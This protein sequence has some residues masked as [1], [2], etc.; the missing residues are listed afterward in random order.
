M[1]S[2]GMSRKRPLGFDK[3]NV[4]PSILGIEVNDLGV[5]VKQPRLAFRSAAIDNDLFNSSKTF[6]N[7]KAYTFF[8]FK[9]IRKMCVF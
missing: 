3:E 2:F 9:C 8:E 7:Y 5:T 6:N 1:N 4:W